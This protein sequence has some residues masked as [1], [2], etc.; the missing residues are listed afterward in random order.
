[1]KYLLD[2][3]NGF[4]DNDDWYKFI[5]KIRVL[6]DGD[7]LPYCIT[8]VTKNIESILRNYNGRNVVQTS[9][10]EFDTE[11]DALAFKLKW[12]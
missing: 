1:M 3:G 10:F 4:H 8:T 12:L 11:E 6:T 2:V 5:H 9:Y 7:E